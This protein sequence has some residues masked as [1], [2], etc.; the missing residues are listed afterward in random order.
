V[1][2]STVQIAT[3][4]PQSRPA[5]LK[6]LKGIERR[7]RYVYCPDYVAVMRWLKPLLTTRLGEATTRKSVPELLP[8]MDAEVE[9]LGRSLSARTQEV[10]K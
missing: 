9:A 1:L 10:E 4:H 8:Q 6:K 7:K 5:G 3:P 2:R